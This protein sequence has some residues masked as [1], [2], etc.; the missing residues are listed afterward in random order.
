MLDKSKK[1]LKSIQ[2]KNRQRALDKK[3]AR[4]GLTDEVLLEQVRINS[5]RNKEDIPDKS[6][7]TFEKYVQ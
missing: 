3:C 5:E 1:F 7:T 4:D 2:L 6:K